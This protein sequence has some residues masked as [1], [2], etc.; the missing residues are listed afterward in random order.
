MSSRL[1][2][3]VFDAVRSSASAARLSVG[4]SLA[5]SKQLLNST[6]GASLRNELHHSRVSKR[7]SQFLLEATSP[8]SKPLKVQISSKNSKLRSPENYSDV[9]DIVDLVNR[10]SFNKPFEPIIRKLDRQIDKRSRFVFQDG[11]LVEQET[12]RPTPLTTES[13]WW[14]RSRH[15]RNHSPILVE[16]R[17]HEAPTKQ[18]RIITLADKLG[19]LTTAIQER[20]KT[21]LANKFTTLQSLCDRIN[22][23][24]LK[25][26]FRKL[27]KELS[28]QPADLLIRK[29]IKPNYATVRRYLQANLP[30]SI[31]K[32]ETM[33]NKFSLAAALEDIRV[34]SVGKKLA[35]VR[36]KLALQSALDSF[37]QNLNEAK[38]AKQKEKMLA[39]LMKLDTYLLLLKFN[40][41][42][43]IKVE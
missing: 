19:E 18:D 40:S 10:D 6:S 8:Q 9:M 2:P 11:L 28:H 37:K 4:T 15:S 17:L 1:E 33:I 39:F 23:T 5:S 12:I 35:V 21:A 29:A 13:D 27:V 41:F 3:A 14:P 42:Y 20:R 7:L 16:S 31:E 22:D 26:T 30:A 34:V 36:R 24:R 32:S 43:S 25:E 38:T